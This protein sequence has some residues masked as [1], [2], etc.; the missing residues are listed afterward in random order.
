MDEHDKNL[1]I[2][3]EKK[4]KA[5]PLFEKAMMAA[6]LAKNWLAMEL[7]SRAFNEKDYAVW[8]FNSS[9]FFGVTGHWIT[10]I[11]KEKK[12]SD[13]ETYSLRNDLNEYAATSDD[14]TEE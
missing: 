5:R 1:M 3:K 12:L 2:M 14:K 9:A 4:E 8:G 10:K 7:L 11:H 13:K 6:C